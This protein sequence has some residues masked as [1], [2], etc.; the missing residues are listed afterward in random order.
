MRRKTLGVTLLM[1]FVCLLSFATVQAE[2]LDYNYMQPAKRYA[3]ETVRTVFE[4]TV[5]TTAT[6]INEAG[7][8]TVHRSGNS[9]N[10]FKLKIEEDST[11]N[12]NVLVATSEGI[13]NSSVLQMKTGILSP[14]VIDGS[15]G[16]SVAIHMDLNFQNLEVFTFQL[17]G[18]EGGVSSG[19]NTNLAGNLL[20]IKWTSGVG[21]DF[22]FG[23]ASTH[24]SAS[25][26]P[27]VRNVYNKFR[28]FELNKW[29]RIVFVIN[30]NGDKTQD[31]ID[32]YADGQLQFTKTGLNAD[33]NQNI[34]DSIFALQSSGSNKPNSIKIANVFTTRLNRAQSITA[35]PKTVQSGDV[36][37]LNPTVIG[38][39]TTF[40]PTFGE[41]VVSFSKTS[42]LT[43][44]ATTNKFTALDVT[45]ETNVKVKFRVKDFYATDENLYEFNTTTTI[46]IKPAGSI[47]PDPE[48]ITVA[49]EGGITTIQEGNYLQMLST[50]TPEGADDTVVWSTSDDSIATVDQ[51]GL[52]TTLQ[53]GTVEVIATS[54]SLETVV[55]RLAITV[56]EKIESID[57]ETIIVSSEGEILEVEEGG[58]LQMRATVTP[59]GVDN[60]VVWSTSND[61]IAT[62]DDKG[63][64]T[65]LQAGTVD[66]IAT[67]AILDTVV[68]RLKI[69]VTEKEIINVTEIE[70]K[71]LLLDTID[72]ITGETLPLNSLFG[73][74]PLEATDTVINYSIKEGSDTVAKIED[75]LL[76]GVG[77]GEVTLVATANSDETIQKEVLIKVRKGL[78]TGLNDFKIDTVFNEPNQ[79]LYKD[80]WAGRGYSSKQYGKIQMVNDPVFGVVPMI[81]GAGETTGTGGSY[82]AK[83]LSEEI[84]A[85]KDYRLRGY[86]RVD[87]LEGLNI[88][89]FQR[90]DAKFFALD[91]DSLKFNTNEKFYS[92]YETATSYF[93]NKIANNGWVYFETAPINFDSV[94]GVSG[95]AIELV[96]YNNNVGIDAKYAHIGL[97][98][99]DEVTAV[100]LSIKDDQG[101]EINNPILQVG[102]TL[103]VETVDMIPASATGTPTYQ[104]KDEEIATVSPEGLITAVKTGNV[105]IT[106][107]CAGKTETIAV[108]VVNYLTNI[109]SEDEEVTLNISKTNNINLIFTPIDYIDNLVLT[110]K[111][112]GIATAEFV[113][114][115]VSVTAKT[116]GETVLTIAAASNPNV[117]VDVTIKVEDALVTDIIVKEDGVEVT[118][119]SLYVG[120]E[121]TLK[122]TILP[123]IRID[124]SMTYSSD[125]IEVV[126][127]D[128]TG[129]L[130]GIGV[131]EAKVTLTCGNYTEELTVKVEEVPVI[132]A[133]DIIVDKTSLTLEINGNAKINATLTPEGAEGTIAFAS[134][135]DKV[136][137]VDEKGNVTAV[138]AG[139]AEIVISCETLSKKVNVVV[140]KPVVEATGISVDVDKLTLDVDGKAKINAILTPEGAKGTIV[141]TSS[142]EE[143]A[144]VD[145]NGNVTAVASGEAEI[146]VSYEGFSEKVNVIVNNPNVKNPE[147]NKTSKV[148]LIAISS[149][150]VVA[151][152]C[153]LAVVLLKKKI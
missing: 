59:E 39:D 38:I 101:L 10:N 133:T 9:D 29:F 149:V 31:S 136:V 87:V 116:L 81:L 50:V 13:D 26:Y 126:T 100:D 47:V 106:V 68:G 36:F 138:G 1:L 58:T 145:E 71:V 19:A 90:L 102:D 44:D 83:H 56:T 95:L 82:L 110:F 65:T 121:L 43:Y 61:S 21:T 67:S 75:G 35:Q 103:K 34:S 140:N 97:I 24:T 22:F 20:H 150:V 54:A 131:G 23:D 51:N 73:V 91:A 42:P 88:Q 57:P 64:V 143:V 85:G 4:N 16:N 129:K 112:E 40:L 5:T 104:S 6:E 55:G 27:S 2:T 25:S 3:E 115:V 41:Y 123:V 141:Y 98:E 33:F 17:Y 62:V 111:D 92:C 96:S 99:E 139:E 72:L 134:S 127:V 148:V 152:L 74:L 77:A 125:N 94:S 128:E 53:A 137:T 46:T 130:V 69:T 122:P 86:V 119:V 118:E 89:F 135:N 142:N 8:T 114:G 52:V 66:I 109:A 79:D 105:N 146:V 63:L 76:V 124:K 93:V 45:E 113:D 147:D 15:T 107:I 132:V 80:G 49:A 78:Y 70:R 108:K 11:L 7:I 14:A 60:T 28:N 84:T 18:R 12:Q 151:G 153:G 37:E 117:K 48:T 144:T 120:R 32:I 30:D